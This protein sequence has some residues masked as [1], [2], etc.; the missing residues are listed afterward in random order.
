MILKAT[1]RHGNASFKAIVT[2]LGLWMILLM[3][4]I[5]VLNTYS[6]AQYGGYAG[7]GVQIGFDANIS[8]FG[9]T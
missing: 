8:S 2:R 7:A 6:F 4:M 9:K 3:S 5:G 1:Y